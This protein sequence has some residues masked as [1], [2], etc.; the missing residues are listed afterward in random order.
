MKFF[1]NSHR[2]SS[3]PARV[4]AR[5]FRIGIDARKLGD[6]GI[7]DYVWNL[8]VHLHRIDPVN[9]YVLLHQSPAPG[10]LVRPAE[11][12]WDGSGKYSLREQISLPWHAR[13]QRMDL[14]HCPHYV[15]PLLRPCPLV[16]TV[17]DVIHV[18]LG[19]LWSWP[20]RQY[21]LFMLR[22]A[23]GAARIITVSEGSKRD[24]MERLGFAAEQIVVIP[25][26]IGEEFRPVRDPARLDTLRARYGIAGPFL[27]AAGNPR[28]R[29][30]NVITA[31]RAFR[32]LAER[33]EADLALVIAGGAP[34][35]DIRRDLLEAAGPS[36]G[37]VRFAGFVPQADLPALY[38]AASAFVWP[39]LYE[40]FGLPPAQAMACGTPVVSSNASVMPEILGDAALLVEPLEAE[41]YAEA[42]R[43][44]LDDTPLRQDLVERGRR[45]AARYSWPEHARRTLQVYEEVL[46]GR[47]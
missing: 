18:V 32:L 30:K 27:L 20:A 35:D 14:L 31:V 37:R 17:H 4:T 24:L 6:Y 47:R 11:W 33:G 26:G 10:P 13:R 23:Q 29:H 3:M 2:V 38:S 36:A 28:M 42:L 45:R 1:V 7:G 15:V 40:G 22:R 21:A 41:A 39:S 46:A 9:Q 12:V 43:R 19:H 34:P 44:V 25:N 16:V 5:P 8:I